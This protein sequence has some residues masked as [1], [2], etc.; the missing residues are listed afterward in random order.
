MLGHVLLDDMFHGRISFSGRHTFQNN[1]TYGR[2]VV[3]CRRSCLMGGHAMCQ[4]MSSGWHILQED[5][6]YWKTCLTGGLL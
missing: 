4:C 1:M 3:L 6:S 2:E 5:V